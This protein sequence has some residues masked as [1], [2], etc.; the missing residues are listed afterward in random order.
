MTGYLHVGI[1]EVYHLWGPQLRD[2]S[3]YTALDEDDL[4]DG[5]DGEAKHLCPCVK[6]KK[7]YNQ[8]YMEY[9]LPEGTN[10]TRVKKDLESIQDYLKTRSE[11][12][13]VTAS[14]GGTP[15]RYNLVRSIASPSLSYGEL[16][17]DFISSKE[18]VENMD[19][20]QAYVER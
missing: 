16:I 12:A 2:L 15:G 3:H 4:V 11:V 9:K 1:A 10:S 14:I 20:I 17:I 5:L 7:N 18:L 13:H 8:L 19:E 6:R